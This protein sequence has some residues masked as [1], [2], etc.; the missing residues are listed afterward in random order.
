MEG[1]SSHVAAHAVLAAMA[2]SGTG[3]GAVG[4]LGATAVD[5]LVESG[6]LVPATIEGWSRPAFELAEEIRDLAGWLGLDDIRT[7]PRGDLAP[8]LSLELARG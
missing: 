4:G 8:A 6:E 1:S 7:E 2:R 3:V 5:R